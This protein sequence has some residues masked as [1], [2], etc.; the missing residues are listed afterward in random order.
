MQN[1][2]TALAR[3]NDYRNR[4]DAL[5]FKLTAARQDS[6]DQL[7]RILSCGFTRKEASEMLTGHVAEQ[8]EHDMIRLEEL[9]EEAELELAAANRR[10]A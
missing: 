6:E 3:A 2:Q 5:R 4:A 1:T 10:A 7:G 8:L 9:A